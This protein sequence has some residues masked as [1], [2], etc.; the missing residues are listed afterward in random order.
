MTLTPGTAGPT[1]LRPGR[2]T[3]DGWSCDPDAVLLDQTANYMRSAPAC[4]PQGNL[5]VS[6]HPGQASLWEG[7]AGLV[8][9]K[10]PGKGRPRNAP[11]ERGWWWRWFRALVATARGALAAD[12]PCGVA[13]HPKPRF[14]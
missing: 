1:L 9:R 8:D 7:P 12:R 14:L 2:Q 6:I 3:P 4:H 5:V 11:R 10:V 13:G